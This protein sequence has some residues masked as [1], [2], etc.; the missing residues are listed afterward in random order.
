MKTLMYLV[1]SAIVVLA[2]PLHAAEIGAK[3]PDDVY[4][5]V[6]QLKQQMMS[7]RE[8]NGISSPWPSVEKPTDLAPRH[9]L[10][11]N[12]EVLDK[13]KRLRRI[14]KM[15]PIT[16]PLFPTRNIT[17]NE[18]Y[19]MTGRL[20]EEL[21]LFPEV[22]GATTAPLEPVTGK[23][24][25]EVYQ[26]LWNISLAMNPLLGVRGLKPTDVYGQSLKIL[27]QVRFL[28]I[29]Q[30]LSVEIP[31]PP[32]TEGKRPNHALQQAFHL[33]DKIALAEH[34]LWIEPIKVPK[35]PRREIKPGEVYD[36]LLIVQAEV[37]RVK[38][39][40][41]VDRDIAVPEL[42]GQKTPDDVLYN[43]TWATELM[44]QFPNSAPIKQYPQQSLNKTPNQLYGLAEH[45]TEELLEYRKWRGIQLMPREIPRQANL[46]AHNVYQKTL[47]VMDKVSQVR[48]QEGLGALALPQGHLRQITLTEVYDLLIRLDA[49]LE[50]IYARIGMP[51]VLAEL[52][53]GRVYSDKTESD[54][55]QQMWTISYLLDALLG[56]EGYTP[57]DVFK[58]AQHVVED[59]KIIAR[60]MGRPIANL[61]PAPLIHGTQHEDVLKQS[62]IMMGMLKKLKVRI[63]LLGQ[64]QP[65]SP[66]PDRVTPDDVYNG[67][68][69]IISELEGIKIYLGI[70]EIAP[71]SRDSGDKTPSQV[72]QQLQLATRLLQSYIE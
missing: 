16:V 22:A 25:S 2:T 69:L 6:M 9:V 45:I 46:Q 53:H 60:A 31:P 47:R 49:E 12:L 61:D 72:L 37:E 40:L 50:L 56:S 30:S 67:I 34:N 43:L 7:L 4:Q 58:Q 28:R 15:G 71:A 51:A 39:R 62:Q 21:K 66:T 14:R 33:L 19:D 63:G 42:E 57:T 10:Q 24:S 48:E 59:L 55:F 52:D 17:P 26:E 11:K 5:R 68:E 44:P 70:T 38:Y 23:T 41:G 8:A 27:G 32:R 36:A 64:A 18:V 1:I 3:T 35:V 20:I 13:I 54:V 29:S 65:L